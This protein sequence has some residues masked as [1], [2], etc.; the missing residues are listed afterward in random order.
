VNEALRTLLN[1]PRLWRGRNAGQGLPVQAS[2]HAGLD[3]VL[4][5]GGWPLGAVSEFIVER[6]GLGEL[7]LLLPALRQRAG[8]V[9]AGGW[10]LWIAPPF[11]PYAPALVA[12]GIDLARTLVV[13]APRVSDALW[14]AEQAL[15]SGQC[16]TLLLWA[17]PLGLQGL[18]RLQLAAE[19]GQG[20][21]VLF[22]PPA[23]LREH[24][25]AAL[26]LHLSS[27]PA[28][29]RLHLLKSRGGQPAMLDMSD[30][31]VA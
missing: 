10:L 13:Q 28:G 23:A 9:D 26:R 11:N 16:G 8:Q 22:R 3:A 17:H 21:V 6:Y 30:L 29:L 2:G 7:S 4:P 19:A 15:R 1:D 20:M 27:T 12:A 25:V 31:P 24:S 14:A 5:G 18:R